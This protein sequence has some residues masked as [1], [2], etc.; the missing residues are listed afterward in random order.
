MQKELGALCN[1]LYTK[2]I[3]FAVQS[4]ECKENCVCVGLVSLPVVDVVDVISYFT[5]RTRI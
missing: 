1:L 2:R 4:I 3:G 5:T